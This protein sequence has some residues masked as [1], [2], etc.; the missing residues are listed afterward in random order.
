MSMGDRLRTE[1]ER[2]GYTQPGF[3]ELTGTTKRTQFNYEKN[4]RAPDGNYLAAIAAVGADVL[5]IVTGQ[6][7]QPM[8][9]TASLPARVRALV[10][11]Y[12]NAPESG[13]KVI[14]QTA[15]FAAQPKAARGGE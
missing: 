5:Y 9:A 7:S 6:R 10:D 12:E 3:A 14:E 1:R 2:L 15:S 4:E 11:N 13:K 8:S